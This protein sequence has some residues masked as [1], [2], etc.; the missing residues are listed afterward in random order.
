M[1]NIDQQKRLQRLFGW[2]NKQPWCECCKNNESI[3][4][5]NTVAHVEKSKTP[6]ATVYNRYWARL[7]IKREQGARDA[8]K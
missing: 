3:C 6:C 7:R 4:I 1:T 8:Q 5:G 2:K